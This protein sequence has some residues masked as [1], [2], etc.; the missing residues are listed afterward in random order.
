[1]SKQLSKFNYFILDIYYSDLAYN[2]MFFFIFLVLH[3]Y[4]VEF[5]IIMDFHF[6]YWSNNTVSYVSIGDHMYDKY[7]MT[8]K[9]IKMY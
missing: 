1:M 6:Y 2:C 5:K 3:F 4:F 8:F 9:L 7:R